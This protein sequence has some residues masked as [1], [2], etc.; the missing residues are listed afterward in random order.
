[1]QYSGGYLLYLREGNLVAH[2][3]DTRALKVSGEPIAV[4]EKLDYWNARDEASF[5]ASPNGTL[6]YRHASTPVS[7]PTLMDRSGKE[8]QRI[9]QP[10]RFANLEVSRDGSRLGVL[11]EQD[12]SRSDVWTIDLKRNTMSRATF[13]AAAALTYA[14]SSDGNR[15]AVVANDLGGRK[16]EVWLQSVSGSGP[17]DKLAESTD[18]TAITSWSQDERYLFITI[19]RDQT[20]EDIYYIDLQGER[21]LVPFIQT[22]NLEDS[23]ILSP[24]GKW[25]AYISDESG[26][27]EVYVTAFPGPGN[28][29]Q[30]SSGGGTNPHWSMDGKQLYFLAAGKLMSVPIQNSE[31]FEFGAAAELPIAMRDIEEYTVGA[32]ADQLVVLKH[33]GE[34]QGPPMEV[35]LNWTQRIRK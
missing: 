24:N 22:P 9:G 28:K 14:F 10:G 5:T 34:S 32:G 13:A 19:Q 23:A 8:L 6:V 21:K 12:T 3:F 26:R 7:Q 30:I 2:K 16:N 17:Q 18:F 25:L 15:M 35:V 33:T 11:L 31:T 20:G 1:M 27:A 29:W 4:A